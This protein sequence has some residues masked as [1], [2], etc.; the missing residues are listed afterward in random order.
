MSLAVMLDFASA[1]FGG[2]IA[3]IAVLRLRRTV[4][5]WFFVAGMALLSCEGVFSGLMTMAGEADPG[6]AGHWENRAAL[7]MLLLPGVWLFFS[8]SYARGNYREF[9]NK[10]QVALG[11]AFLVPISL[12]IF[13]HGQL[14]A[15]QVFIRATGQWLFP[16]TLAGW[17]A[18]M[19]TLLS[20]VVVLMQLERT[21]WAS[22]GTMRWRIKFMVLG[23][24]LLFAVR[25]YTA[26]QALVLPVQIT[27]NE[28]II[29]VTGPQS[30]AATVNAAELLLACLLMLRSLF[31]APSEVAVYPS[32]VGLH[33]SV[34]A[35]VAGV[36]LLIVGVLAKVVQWLDLKFSFPLRAF[37]IL[38]GLVAITVLLLSDRVRLHARRFVSRYLQRP[39]YDY[40][41]V[42]RR[43]TEGTASRVT[44]KELCQASVKLA[45]DLSGPLRQHLAG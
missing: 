29:P 32:H 36:Y 40:R 14:V 2:A 26:S 38:V 8:L 39:L 30:S 18:Y 34:T 21:F 5:G 1:F 33:K 44:E 20:A 31:R 6:A 35:M 13:N 41:T 16:L 17:G 9:L 22:V 43:F 15:G 12:A 37:L 23:L 45:A 3:M 19:V 27:V 11:A 25:V 42:W 28:R 24:G 10:W 7:T 4:A